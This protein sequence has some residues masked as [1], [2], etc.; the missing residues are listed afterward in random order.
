[1][2]LFLF[3]QWDILIPKPEKN[4][5][6]GKILRTIP[7]SSIC[8]TQHFPNHAA[9]P[10]LTLLPSALFCTR[11]TR[12]VALWSCSMKIRLNPTGASKTAWFLPAPCT[13]HP[14]ITITWVGFADTWE[15]ILIF[16]SFVVVACVCLFL[17]L[18]LLVLNYLRFRPSTGFRAPVGGASGSVFR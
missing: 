18:F 17:T 12:C 3:L 16:I 10:L 8:M 1:M 2:V 13:I 9:T 6:V 11:P 5:I 14:L 15:A 7:R 4:C